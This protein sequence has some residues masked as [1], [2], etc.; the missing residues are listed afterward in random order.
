VARALPA[1]I[2]LAELPLDAGWREDGRLDVPVVVGPVTGTPPPA[3]H[4]ITIQVVD[5]ACSATVEPADA[6]SEADLD[7]I[8]ASVCA[9]WV[10]TGSPPVIPADPSGEEQPDLAA[11]Q[12]SRPL[13]AAGHSPGRPF[14]SAAARRS[15]AT[16]RIADEWAS[17]PTDR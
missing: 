12:G 1:G 15:K 14:A 16:S 6:L 3:T 17:A 4:L 11:Q 9:E 7:A 13:R 5:G 2:S 10:A 8:A